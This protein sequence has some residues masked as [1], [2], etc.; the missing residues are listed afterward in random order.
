MPVPH[1]MRRSKGDRRDVIAV[2]QRHSSTHQKI[3]L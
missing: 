2:D 3:S 1:Q